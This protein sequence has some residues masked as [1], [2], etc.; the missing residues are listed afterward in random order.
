MTMAITH[1]KQLI[2]FSWALRSRKRS[3]PRCPTARAQSPGQGVDAFLQIEAPLN[4]SPNGAL[5]EVIQEEGGF[6]DPPNFPQGFVEAGFNMVGVEFA[7]HAGG[8]HHPGIDGSHQAQDIVPVFSDGTGVDRGGEQSADVGELIDVAT[9][10]EEAHFADVPE[11]G[12][13]G[14][15]QQVASAPQGILVTAGIDKVAVRGEVS[16]VIQL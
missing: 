15:P 5:G 11:A 1:C 12:F 13:Q 7:Q 3:S 4:P 9:H 16:F 8:R 10:L 14:K 6:S 2:R